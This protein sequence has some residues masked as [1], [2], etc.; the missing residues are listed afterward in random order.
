MPDPADQNA[1]AHADDAGQR[2]RRDLRRADGELTDAR[3]G[4]MAVIPPA[5]SSQ[6]D[7]GKPVIRRASWAE[8]AAAADA[9]QPATRAQAPS[10]APASAPGVQQDSSTSASAGLAAEAGPA[11]S[12]APAGTP[13]FRCV[14]PTVADTSEI[15]EATVWMEVDATALVELREGLKA[16][17]AQVPGLLAFIARF[18]TAGLKTYPELNTRIETVPDGSQEIVSF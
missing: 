6:P 17:G 10:R 1:R 11:P 9:G 2:C 4:T 7:A 18:V 8:A 14:R 15:P 16:G 3:A 12:D 13:A 5:P